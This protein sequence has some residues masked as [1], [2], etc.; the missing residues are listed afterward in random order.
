MRQ[1]KDRIVHHF[2][3]Q[4]LSKKVI[5]EY[6]MFRMR[7]AG[8]HGPDIFSPTAI[9]LIGKASNG[10]MRR[11]NILADK[12][13]LA[14]FVENT[15]NIDARHVQ[16][17]IRD[18]ELAPSNAWI[19]RKIIAIAAVAALSILALAAAAWMLVQTDSTPQ[20]LEKTAI[21]SPAMPVKIAPANT[22]LASSPIAATSTPIPNTSQF[23]QNVPTLQLSVALQTHSAPVMSKPAQKQ[24]NTVPKK[25]TADQETVVPESLLQQ[26]LA[27]TKDMFANTNKTGFSIQLYYTDDPRPIRIERF[28]SRA[29]S[30][31]KLSEIYI[32]PIKIKGK[33][34]FRILYGVYANSEEAHIGLQN[35]PQRYKDA[36]A[37]TLNSLDSY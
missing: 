23:A 1:L 11:V 9:N 15:H 10:L 37:P 35:L 14:A 6:L 12:S 33:D 26:R 13:L 2:N 31:G 8:Y 19:S 30:L 17:A 16:A 3:M 4:P 18:S 36:F 20:K 34:G 32:I 24:R 21:I 28:L 27:A 7:A 5:D 29:K 22:G 25:K